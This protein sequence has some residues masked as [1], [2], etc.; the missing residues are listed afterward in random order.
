LRS[1]EKTTAT[2]ASL[3]PND[4]DQVQGALAERGRAIEAVQG[5]I[6]AERQA[7]RPVSPEMADHLTRDLEVG[8]GILVRLALERDATRLDLMAV[9]RAQQ[10]LR[11]L[12]GPA[13]V[14]PTAIDCRG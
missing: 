5:W 10:M 11:G 8:A 13:P 7:L 1:L 2:L 6:A 9:N 12:G 4:M 3:D 14:G